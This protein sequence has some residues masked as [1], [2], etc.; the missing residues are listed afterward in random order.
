MPEGKVTITISVSFDES[1]NGVKK[2][3]SFKSTVNFE[4]LEGLH[5]KTDVEKSELRAFPKKKKTPFKEYVQEIKKNLRR[6]K[7]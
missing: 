1:V 3:S 7:F 2:G 4:T 6:T 5:E